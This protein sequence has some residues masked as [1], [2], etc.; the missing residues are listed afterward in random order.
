MKDVRKEK[1][2]RFCLHLIC[3]IRVFQSRRI[4]WAGQEASSRQKTEVYMILNL[5]LKGRDYLGEVEVDLSL[6][7]KYITKHILIYESVKRHKSSIWWW[8]VNRK[9]LSQI[10]IT[11]CPTRCNT[12]QSIYYTASS[13][14]MF[15]V[16]TPI[17]R[18]TKNCNYSLR[19]WSY[20]LCSYLYPT[21]PS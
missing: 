6:T 5:K 16:S 15:R 14:Y 18:S 21:W 12:K 8:T 19:Y 3:Q 9:L 1:C 13:L 7:L 11:N 10:Y 2:S 17:I 20:F 4:R